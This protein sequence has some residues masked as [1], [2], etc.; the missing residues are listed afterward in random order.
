MGQDTSYTMLNIGWFSTGRDKA[1]RQ[2][3][4]AVQ[5]NIASGNIQGKISFIFSNREPGE[6][7]ESDCFFTIV[8]SY[9]MPL[10]YLSHRKY[11]QTWQK[12]HAEQQDWR[13]H[14]DQEVNRMIAQFS[15]Q[16]IVLAGYMLIIEKELCS[17]YN[18][19]NLHP[20]PPHGPTGSWQN[21]IWHL[22]D[23]RA[24][25]AGAM[26]HLVTPE[27]DRGPVVSY[28]TF[29]IDGEPF[30]KY[31]A[32][33]D[34]QALFHLIRQHELAHEFPL[35]IATIK[36]LS[37]GDIIIQNGRVTD[38]MGKPVPGYDLSDEINQVKTGIVSSD[39]E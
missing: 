17:Q 18:M 16:L 29:N 34:R 8:Q 26:M 32:N 22:I 12:Q 19:I 13:M 39:P 20:A 6:S 38:S 15:P 10:L 35:I 30:T 23:S 3:L 24:S 25:T 31:W 37:Q 21:V 5:Q 14:Y 2:L 9:H 33:N 4:Q 27:M 11:R 1:A 28:T 36:A 7:V